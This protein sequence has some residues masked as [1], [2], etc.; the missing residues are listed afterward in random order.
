MNAKGQ[1]KST[2]DLG[3][4]T[5]PHGPIPAFHS[6][7]EEAEFWDTHDFTDYSELAE[8]DLDE[9]IVDVAPAASAELEEDFPVRLAPADREA[10]G[11]RA[12]KMGVKPEELIRMWVTERLHREAS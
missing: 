2:V 1:R 8:E 6:I 5:E 7:E 11:R 3:Y 10:L 12:D 9:N 4:P